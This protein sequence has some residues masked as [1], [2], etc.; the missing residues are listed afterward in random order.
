[1]SYFSDP[2]NSFFV[3]LNRAKRSEESIKR[4]LCERPA[5]NNI[6]QIRGIRFFAFG[7]E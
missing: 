2:E 5:H 4:S 6:S 3:I 7:S 1:M